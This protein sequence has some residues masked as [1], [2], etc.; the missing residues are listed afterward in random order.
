MVYISVENSDYETITLILFSN[1]KQPDFFPL[2]NF[3]RIIL[4]RTVAC[5]CL[6]FIIIQG[7]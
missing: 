6:H 3:P 4:Y 7:G 1:K 2:S 5:I